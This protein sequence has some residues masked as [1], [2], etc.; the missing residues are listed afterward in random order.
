MR[1]FASLYFL[2]R[3]PFV[4]ARA[5]LHLVDRFS[6]FR[7]RF[8]FRHDGRQAITP[9]LPSL[10][11]FSVLVPILD[12]C[13]KSPATP[14]S[15]STAPTR[16]PPRPTCRTPASTLPRR[17]LDRRESRIRCILHRLGHGCRGAS[18]Q[19]A[20]GC[21]TTAARWQSALSHENSHEHWWA[22]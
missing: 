6:R 8:R 9:F 10:L 13:P 7:F 17:R 21:S 15:S 18:I 14:C 11:S 3:H 5:V 2:I 20:Y 16:A 1:G 12:I 19:V 4:R 22:R